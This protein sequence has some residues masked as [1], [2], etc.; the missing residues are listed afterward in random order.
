MYLD[1]IDSSTSEFGDLYDELPLWSAPFG[2]LLL[3]HVPMKPGLTVLDIGAGTGFLTIELAERCGPTTSVIAVDPWKAAM[4]RLRRKVNQRGLKNVRLIERDAA[5]LDLPDDSVDVIV[6]NLG[7]NNFDN[8][9]AV[10]AECRVAKTGARLVLTT[11][12]RGHMA[13]FYDVYRGVLIELG[14]REHVDALET[15]INQRATVESVRD[16]L[17]MAGFT[18]TEVATQTFRMRFADGSSL[19]RHSFIRLGFLPGWKSVPPPD[20]LQ[21]T[22]GTLEQRLDEY[23]QA[24]GELVLTVPMACVV[25]TKGCTSGDIVGRWHS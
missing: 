12:L 14:H 3:E 11:N 19:L 23:A 13:E 15:H 7:V 5:I 6:S 1:D 18:P 20:S 24:R 10:L 21:D 16:L 4:D 2:L 8:P 22:F 9:G 25:A 17:A